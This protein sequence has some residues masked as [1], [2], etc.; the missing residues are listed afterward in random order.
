[1]TSILSI[2]V[3][4]S[5]IHIT[6]PFI[7]FLATRRIAKKRPWN[8]NLRKDY[9]PK[10]TV[11]VATYN[12]AHV[13]VDKLRNL[14]E[15]DYPKS[16]LEVIIVDSASTD[17]TASIARTY[18]REND[19]PFRA[20][21][22][23]EK[24]RQG[25]ASALNNAL[26][27][28]S[29]EVVGTSDADCL[30][31]PDSIRS[32]IKYLSDESVAAVCGQEVIVNPSESSATRTETQHR[33]F[34]N[35][36]RVGES[37]I[38]STIAFE[39]ALALYKKAL[40]QRF[41]ESCDDSGSALN[42]VQKGYRT[43]LAP[44]SFFLNPFPSSWSLKLAKK[45]RRAQHLVEIWWRC[46]KLDSRGKLKLDPWISRTN[47]FLHL[48]NP[49]LF[50]VFVITMALICVSYPILLIFMLP[51]LVV[52][53]LRDLVALYITEYLSLIYAIFMQVCGRKQVVWKK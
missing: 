45:T 9:E 51:I 37:K 27:Y 20:S 8:L 4:V 39:G 47:V 44:D 53:K 29:N 33:S 11:I 50:I 2:L 22:I 41:D 49:F 42:L 14:V 17:G 24:K 36:I 26:Q 21:V 30:W 32:A 5:A 13:V 52:P 48:F 7:Y 12:E 31:T 28:A 6:I 34:F 19:L 1:M 40:L 35:N 15:L 23:E 3:V 25:K 38:H 16:K 18:V 43:I 10:V 46:L